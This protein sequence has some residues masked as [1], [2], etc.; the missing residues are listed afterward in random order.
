M[1]LDVIIKDFDVIAIHRLPSCSNSDVPQIIVHLLNHDKKNQL[2]YKAKIT[3]PN[4]D[5]IVEGELHPIYISDHL[6]AANAYLLKKAEELKRFGLVKF[7]WVKNCKIYI[8]ENE[9]TRI[10]RIVCTEDID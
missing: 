4:T 9:D 3:K 6:S 2:I 8:R 1:K 7:V 5:S 10:Y